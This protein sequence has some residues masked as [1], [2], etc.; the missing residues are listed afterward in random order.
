[1]RD[2]LK[3]T[4]GVALALVVAV[5]AASPGEAR[6]VKRCGITIGAGKTGHL[7]G[8]VQCG[9]RCVA[10]PSVPCTAI[11]DEQICP[12]VGSRCAPEVLRL[13]RNAT[14]ELNGFRLSGA[15]EARAIECSD[16]ASGRCT[17]RGPGEIKVKDAHV[18]EG[19]AQHVLLENLTMRGPIYGGV[20][21]DG[22]L[23]LR[24]VRLSGCEPG[25]G[26][27]RAGADIRA[28]DVDLESCTM[29]SEKNVYA[30][31]VRGERGFSAAATIRAGGVVLH[32]PVS[33]RDVFLRGSNVP[34]LPEYSVPG[35]ID[36]L[37]EQR[38]VL[39]RTVVG[40]LQSGRK[41]TL[42][43]AAC[44]RSVRPGSGTWD[45]CDED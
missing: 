26:S 33:A 7:T 23:T 5:G 40:S 35:T 22:R 16:G 29:H 8:D 1:M 42:R 10:D 21:T 37:A 31:G 36:V 27:L 19:H 25:L 44:L 20:S 43:D 18:I 11:E 3:L 39:R 41:P 17:V 4:S 28:R 32:G 34:E 6:D 15:F 12:I 38:L 14:L 45:V 13:E 2:R 9:F 24:E 30:E